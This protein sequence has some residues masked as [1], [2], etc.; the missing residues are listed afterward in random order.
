MV[1]TICFVTTENMTTTAC[2]IANTDTCLAAAAK[3]LLVKFNHY[4][5]LKYR[6]KEKATSG[7]ADG[8][9]ENTRKIGQL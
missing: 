8:F 2:I 5:Q 3:D 4:I 6:F 9:S 7:R 1:R